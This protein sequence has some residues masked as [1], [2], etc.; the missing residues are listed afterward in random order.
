MNISK[1]D[2]GRP[3]NKGD[4]VIVNYENASAFHGK[5]GKVIRI[6]FKPAPRGKTP[7]WWATVRC[8]PPKGLRLMECEIH[9]SHLEPEATNV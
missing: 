5:H 8:D 7:G 2:N 3:Y 9:T 4:R 1:P 6:V